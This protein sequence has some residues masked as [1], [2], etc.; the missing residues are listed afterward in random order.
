MR[1]LFRPVQRRASVRPFRT[2]AASGRS[3]AAIAIVAAVNV[4]FDPISG[5]PSG[6]SR[7]QLWAI[8]DISECPLVGPITA[9]LLRILLRN[10]PIFCR[11]FTKVSP[12]SG[13][14]LR[15][16]ARGAF[17]V[18]VKK[19]VRLTGWV[20]EVCGALGAAAGLVLLYVSF[21]ARLKFGEWPAYSFKT[22][23]ENAH[24]QWPSLQ[25]TTT[26]QKAVDAMPTIFLDAPA[27]TPFLIVGGG[28]YIFGL[29]SGR[30]LD[31]S[32]LKHD[33]AG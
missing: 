30:I 17:G 27:W 22:L 16:K 6:Q 20:V 28:I 24:A 4:R 15:R 5:H 1:R 13:E 33:N 31:E 14:T 8:A 10:T 9:D 11:A 21:L 12:S 2:T 23:C 25:L 18:I 26:L 29:V 7:C 19:I 32:I 3:S